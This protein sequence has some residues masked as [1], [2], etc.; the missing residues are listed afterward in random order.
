MVAFGIS[1]FWLRESVLMFNDILVTIVNAWHLWGMRTPTRVLFDNTIA[2]IGY[3]GL[4]WEATHKCAEEE[5]WYGLCLPMS[6][7]WRFVVNSVLLPFWFS[8]VPKAPQWAMKWFGMRRVRR[9]ERRRQI[10]AEERE[11]AE[12]LRKKKLDDYLALLEARRR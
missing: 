4:D 5:R 11:R 3:W 2:R 12:Q 6:M 9:E 1:I 8:W 10:E 7:V